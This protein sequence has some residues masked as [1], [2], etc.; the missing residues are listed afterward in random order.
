MRTS[1]LVCGVLS[2]LLSGTVY[3]ESED[4]A[5][6]AAAARRLRAPY[7]SIDTMD[8]R[9]HSRFHLSTRF[10]FDDGNEAF[11]KS[12]LF[13][14]EAHASIRVAEG[15][16][17]VGT[18][19]FGLDAPNPGDNGF[20]VGNLRVGGTGGGVIH[21]GEEDSP[22]SPELGLGGAIDVYAPTAPELE[23]AVPGGGARRSVSAVR[24]LRSYDPALYLARTMAFRARAH[25]ELNLGY[26]ATQVELGLTPAFT[27]E[28]DSEFFMLFQWMFR[29]AAQPVPSI[30]PYVELGNAIHLGSDAAFDLTLPVHLTFGVRAHM[31]IADPAFFFTLDLANATPIFGIDLA[32]ILRGRRTRAD[33]GDMEFLDEED[34]GF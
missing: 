24:V 2:T 9:G 14:Y 7:V 32:G 8:V 18:L 13:V 29:L 31:G 1:A 33:R 17:I 30:E 22:V 16:A 27:L 21:F 23:L 19:P 12:S 11:S 28:A 5:Y 20:F 15:F 25:A 6:D 10:T 3:G 34:F 4:V 26:V